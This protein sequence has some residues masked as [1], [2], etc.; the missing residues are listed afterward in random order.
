MNRLYRSTTDRV[1]AGVAGG[2]A[3]TYDWDPALVRIVWVILTIFTGVVP[4]LLV[5]IVMAI[6]VPE[7]PAA[8]YPGWGGPP[9]GWT[10]PPGWTP[11]ESTPPPDWQAPAATGAA[12]APGAAG[13]PAGG[14]GPDASAGGAAAAAG[15]AAGAGAG[16]S[17]GPYAGWTAPPGSDYRA[18]QAS[19]REQRRAERAAWRAQRRSEPGMGSIVVGGILVILGAVLLLN[20]LVPSFNADLFWPLALILVGG[21]FLV[22]SFR[23]WGSGG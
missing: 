2:M 10:A 13:S 6:V 17:G 23:H 20:L 8:S 5:Y 1:F 14:S 18:Q 7:G 12:A 4:F 22:A 19:W 11:P 3:E 15:A 21:A 9:P 16:P